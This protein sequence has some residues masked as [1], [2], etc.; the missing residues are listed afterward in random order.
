MFLLCITTI[1]PIFLLWP[2]TFDPVSYLTLWLLLIP[3]VVTAESKTTEGALSTSLPSTSIPLTTV[4]PAV[5]EGPMSTRK[6]PDNLD[7]C[8]TSTLPSICERNGIT[9]YTEFEFPNQYSQNIGEAEVVF[10]VFLQPVRSC[11]NLEATKW[12]C[13]AFFPPCPGTEGRPMC[14]EF[15]EGIENACKSSFEGNLADLIDCSIYP[16]NGCITFGGSKSPCLYIVMWLHG[17]L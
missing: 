6:L 14:R 1:S 3:V 8:V 13:Y 5:T 11:Q 4:T 16:D 10:S 15:C 12:L 2:M 17:V 9:P 7:Q